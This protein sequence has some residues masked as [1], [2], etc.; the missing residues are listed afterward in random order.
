MYNIHLERRLI[1]M[2]APIDKLKS[3][4]NDIIQ[5]VVT[6]ACTLNCSNCTQLLP[7][8]KDYLH[9]SLECFREAVE[10]VREWPGVVALFGGNPCSHPQFPELCRILAEIIP[11]QERRGLWSNDLLKHGDVARATFWPNGRFNLNA[12]GVARAAMGIVANLPNKIIP[13]SVQGGAYHAPILAHWADMGLTEA[14][15]I[16]ARESCGINQKWSGAIVQRGGRPYAYF[17]E[18]AAALDGIRGENIGEPAYPGWWKGTMRSDDTLFPAQVKMCCDRGCGVPLKLKAEKDSN[19]TYQ[20]SPAWQFQVSPYTATRAV[21]IT[22]PTKDH[23]HE[24]TDYM[25]VRGK[26]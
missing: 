21:N 11:Q 6:T 5:I 3:G 17:C 7:F 8:R 22:E 12:H 13:Q 2:L 18:V 15:W 16:Q 14:Q 25:S 24:V 19:E 20:V 4:V 9:M 23:T 26:Q 1:S 10:S